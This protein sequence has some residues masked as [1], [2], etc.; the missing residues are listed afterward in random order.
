MAETITLERLEELLA[1]ASISPVHRALWLLLWEGDLPVLDLLALDVRDVHLEKREVS[2]SSCRNQPA[3]EVDFSERAA[4]LLSEL[5][6]EREDGPLFAVGSRALS[7][8]TA[9]QG[10]Q[11]QGHA[12]HAFRT[13]GKRHRQDSE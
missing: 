9:M 11:E 8:E 10:A 4:G 3:G 12:I 5:I 2:T 13:G 7:W 1:D 6:G